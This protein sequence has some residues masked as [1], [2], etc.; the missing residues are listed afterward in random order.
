VLLLLILAIF[1]AYLVAPLVALLRRS[2]VVAGR[3]RSLPLPAA[4]GVVYAVI[5][6]ALGVALWLLLPVVGDQFSQLAREAPAYVAKAQLRLQTWQ[7]YERA[8]LSPAQQAAVNDGADRAIKAA[9]SGV[10]NGLLPFL[11]TLLG[12]L[13][14]LVLVPILAFFLLKDVNP[15]RR[16]LLR[17]VPKGRL[18]SRSEE[19][20]DDVNA[21][22]AAYVRA[23]L[24]ACLIVGS[25]CAIGFAV[26]GVPY[27]AVLGLAAGVVEFIPLAGPLAIGAVAVVLAG[28]QSGGQAFATFVFLAVLRVVE[29]YVVYPRIMGRGIDLHPLAV[30]LAIL[31]GAEVGGLAGIFLSIPVV[32]VLSVAVRHGRDH[33]AEAPPPG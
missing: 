33:L 19:F 24:L 5:F 23:Q 4:I 1:F 29:D 3:A 15:L 30:I 14:W 8:H 2:V 7:S 28:F 10:Q 32:A 31:A 25:A 18:R 20:F 16:S 26:I 13:P 12:Y 21:T 6:G 22:L 27:A 17:L 11:A 9:V